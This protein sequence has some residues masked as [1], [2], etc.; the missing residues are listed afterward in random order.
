[1]KTKL[2]QRL[3]QLAAI[4]CLVWMAVNDVSRSGFISLVPFGLFGIIFLV[5]WCIDKRF[6]QTAARYRAAKI[7]VWF[8]IS[9][10]LIL[11]I[12]SF[13]NFDV[14]T[15]KAFSLTLNFTFILLVVMYMQQQRLSC[16]LVE[17]QKS[18]AIIQRFTI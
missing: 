7:Q 12:L 3:I 17:E 9:L 13:I 18:T 8:F 16:Q 11:T 4:A 5:Q 1:M 2:V 15:S 14:S 6:P 10:A